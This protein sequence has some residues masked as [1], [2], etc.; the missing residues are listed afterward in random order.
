LRNS[1]GLAYAPSEAVILALIILWVLA[2]VVFFGSL[3]VIASVPTPPIDIA[4][5]Q[6]LTPAVESHTAELTE[7]VVATAG[8]AA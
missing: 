1:R 2:S 3:L 8:H 7:S 5:A 6:Q 4:S